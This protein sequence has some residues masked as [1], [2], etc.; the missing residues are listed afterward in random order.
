[1]SFGWIVFFSLLGVAALFSVAVMLISFYKLFYAHRRSGLGF[2]DVAGLDKAVYEP[3]KDKMLKLMNELRNMPHTDVSIVSYDG[4]ALRGRYYE[5]SKGAPVD[6]LL[7]GYR[8][9]AE[10]DF[11][12]IA[13]CCF[14]LGHNV[15]LVDQRA[16]GRSEGRLITFGVKESRDCLSW[17]NFVLSEINK[18]AKIILVG[19]SMGAATVMNA[20]EGQLPDNVIGAVADCGYTSARAVIKKVMRDMKLPATLFYFYARAAALIFGGFDPDAVSSVGAMKS[21]RIPMLFFHGDTDGFI[22]YEMSRENFEACA[23]EKKRL[24]IVKGAEHGMCFIS[25]MESYYRE[26]KSFFDREE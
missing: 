7:H 2:D 20:C 18:D 15:L 6:I 24:V 13:F 23:S 22:P 12:G 3:Y 21:C 5:K 26:V 19:I 16:C 4:L 11:C 14:A 8:G 1:M 9:S 17:I 25:D 10:R